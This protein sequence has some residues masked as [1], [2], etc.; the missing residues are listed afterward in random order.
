[1]TRK[2]SVS[3]CVFVR[4]FAIMR[5]VDDEALARARLFVGSIDTTLGHIGELRSA[6]TG[7]LHRDGIW[8]AADLVSRCSDIEITICKE[9]WRSSRSDDQ[10]LFSIQWRRPPLDLVS[11]SL[12]VAGGAVFAFRDRHYTAPIQDERRGS[13]TGHFAE[14]PRCN[15]F[16]RQRSR[17]KASLLI[18]G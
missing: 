10:P 3:L 15:T 9:R 12:V 4:R 5:E 8:L 11:F 18:T 1:V 6:E 17:R 2:L 16:P 13:R 14:Y 7:A